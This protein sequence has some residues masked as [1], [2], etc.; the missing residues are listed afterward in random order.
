M[1]RRGKIKHCSLDWR[2]A[3]ARQEAIFASPLVGI[4]TLNESGS[5]ESINPTAE[6]MFGYAAE[7]LIRRDVSCLVDLSLA[8]DCS[9]GTRL[10][11]IITQDGEL[12]ELV[13]RRYDGT[14]FP[15]DFALAEMPLGKRRMFVVFV[16][17]I[18]QRK[19]NERLKDDFVATVSHELRTPMTSIGGSLGL[20]IGGAAGALPPSAERLLKIAYSNSQRLVR[21]INGILDIE[22]IESGK[23]AFD[24]HPLDLR[25]LVEQGIEATRGYADGFGVRVRLEARAAPAMVRADADRILQVLTNLLS[26][27][28]KFSPAGGE[29]VVALEDVGAAVRVSVRD[30]GPGIPDSFKPHLFEK[31]AQA[32]PSDLDRK[33]GTGLGLNIAKQ[34]IDQHGG[35]VGYEP[36]PPG[37]G[38]VFYFE[39][40]RLAEKSSVVAAP[41]AA[42]VRSEL[43]RRPRILHV[44]DD[45]DVLVLV[46][47]VIGAD[48]EVISVASIEEARHALATVTVD[49]ALIDLALADGDGLDLLAELHDAGGR[50]IPAVVFSG[51]DADPDVARRVDAVLTKSQAS[52]DRLPGILRQMAAGNATTRSAQSG[53]EVV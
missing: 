53:R 25:P 21:L 2:E 44:D 39:L 5:I 14:T 48:A 27:A 34:I 6:R 33:G 16:R 43:G 20:L 9:T 41:S 36:A 37:G 29:V 30:R 19:R 40:A 24:M 3:M 45:R 32:Q 50:M 7:S 12:R 46:A 51:H 8:K 47:E 15:V 26:N 18:S 13:G 1:T 28:I 49:V 22:K 10:R 42:A 31:F 17:D 38:T 52:L 35:I 23:A 4:L 11:Q